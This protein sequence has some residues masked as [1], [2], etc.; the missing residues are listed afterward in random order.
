MGVFPQD[1]RYRFP[2]TSFETY[3]QCGEGSNG[4]RFLNLY[5]LAG[6]TG[7]L[8]SATAATTDGA[9][10]YAWSAN[11]GWM[12]LAPS[13]GGVRVNDGWL[14]GYAW[15]ENIGWIKLGSDAGG[16]YANTN[17]TDWGVNKDAAGNLSGYAWSPGAGWINF[18]PSDSQVVIDAATG[19]FSGYAW[20]ESIGWVRFADPTAAGVITA[21][22]LDP[23]TAS[24]DP[25]SRMR[26]RRSARVT[27]S[28]VVDS[29]SGGIPD[30]LDNAPGTQAANHCSGTHA[31]LSGTIAAGSQ[32]S[33]RATGSITATATVAN[34]GLLAMIAPAIGL[35][36]GFHAVNGSR[37]FTQA[38]TPSEQQTGGSS[39]AGALTQ[40]LATTYEANLFPQGSR[41]ASSGYIQDD[42]Q[43]YWQVPG[44]HRYLDAAMP[45]APDLYN[46]YVAGHSYA[47]S[48]AALAALDGSEVVEVDADG[49]LITA[50]I[51]ADNYFEMYVNG[52][53]VAKDP[54]PFTE[55]NSN[56][57][58]FRVKQPFSVAMLLVD[59]EEN[60]GTGTEANRGS[61]AHPGD[62]GMVAVF[63]D[64][65]G[66]IIGVSDASWK[67]QTFYTAPI[68][69]LTCLTESGQ[70]RLSGSCST[71]APS[72]LNGVYAVHWAKPSNWMSE[73][74][75]DSAWPDASTF[76]NATVGV[77]NKPA[78]TQF[79]D[80]FDDPGQDAQFI[81]SSNLVLDNEVVVRGAIGA[82]FQ[83]R[84]RAVKA[85]AILP[86]SATCDG[87]D[88][89][90]S[91][92]L[93]WSGA[94]E[95]T[96]S[97][98]L[99]MHH[100]PNPNDAPDYT[101]AHAYWSLFDIPAAAN[102]LAEGES[103]VGAFGINTVDG[104]QSYTAPCSQDSSAHDYTLT[105]LALSTPVGGLGLSGSVTD[106]ATLRAVA[107]PYTLDSASL[108]L[109]RSRYNPNEDSHL[110]TR[111]ADTC[112]TKSAAFAPYSD[113]VS[114][115]CNGDTLTVISKT[116]LP[117]RSE[118]DVDKANV[119]IRSWI[120]RVPIP[121]TTAWSLPITPTYLSAPASN[122]NIHHP[123]GIAVDGIPILSYIKEGSAEEVAQLGQDYSARDTA[124]L[125]EIDQC[126]GHAGNG[127][128]YHLHTAPF[129]LMDSHDPSQPLAYMFDGLP[130]YFGTAGGV[131]TQGGTDYGG[132]RYAELDYRPQKVKTGE[133]PLDEC[134]AYD[135]HGDGSEYVYYSSAD[136]PYSIG[137]YRALADQTAS[138]SGGPHW[139]QERDLSWSGSQVVLTDY[140][141]LSFEG[142]SWH[143]IEITPSAGNN[144]IAAGDVALILYR[145]L[146]AGE[147]GY[148]ANANCYA[149]R[150]R[151]D[152]DDTTGVS[153]TQAVHCR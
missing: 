133:R 18:N 110:P 80:Q 101:K 99:T 23:L 150:Y 91:I 10:Q 132:G 90:K 15:A 57:V 108:T 14:A 49:E 11:T 89:G 74:Y 58:R 40:G 53:P 55:F 3:G 72:D 114:V 9:N 121:E 42:T 145:Q 38:T 12:N 4:M 75:D 153:D 35:A 66:E 119:G 54:V 112:A 22:R 107:E 117:Y 129:C 68:T 82:S 113:W 60:L 24:V 36:D 116:Q 46:P 125:G 147:S 103:G 149:F 148:D 105:L 124:L 139:T 115:D 56:I 13:D 120:G 50:Y 25:H 67:A 1:K 17:T 128:D 87:T 83:L 2:Y 142:Q 21:E 78:Y 131:L 140:D 95:G 97:F 93:D 32:V 8:A 86:L 84:S 44:E 70:Q 81:W 106:L 77:D 111:V 127:E 61:S 73:S 45:F 63:A 48:N 144:R 109:T 88:R 43:Q 138:V 79:T 135:L 143:F 69:D 52:A 34:G 20:G 62:G 152:S 64:A 19:E 151:L 126:G 26:A 47:N 122:I 27:R 85:D 76:T 30:S 59:W 28:L 31:T 65:S 51:F 141:T 41:V 130:L 137:C 16:P 98:A 100:F 104:Q 5:L 96:Q 37:L 102:A 136:A 146:K 33:C 118:L 7:L 29:D 94:P 134:N 123:I 39:G 92:P 71:A 6:L